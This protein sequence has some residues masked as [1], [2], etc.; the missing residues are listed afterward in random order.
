MP[1]QVHQPQSQVLPVAPVAPGMTI[2]TPPVIGGP[3][4]PPVIGGPAP[5]IP[6]APVAPIAPFAGTPQ[7][8]SNVAQN[9]VSIEDQ[10]V[11][12][13]YIAAQSNYLKTEVINEKD[14]K[15]IYS[16]FY[17]AQSELAPNAEGKIETTRKVINPDGTENVEKEENFAEKYSVVRFRT[18][19]NKEWGEM[20]A[21]NYCQVVMAE[22]KAA[23]LVV[24]AVMPEGLNSEARTSLTNNL[25]S[26]SVYRGGKSNLF[27]VSE[28]QAIQFIGTSNIRALQIHN[29]E[30]SVGQEEGPDGY[31]VI[32]SRTVVR[33]TKAG[34]VVYK[35][36]Y[37]RRSKAADDYDQAYTAS[38]PKEV[39]QKYAV[40]QDLSD[41][42]GTTCTDDSK[43]TNLAAFQKVFGMDIS[44]SK[45]YGVQV[46]YNKT[47]PD[48]AGA[49]NPAEAAKEAK[50]KT[51]INPGDKG[52]DKFESLGLDEKAVEMFRKF[53]ASTTSG[54]K[55]VNISEILEKSFR[56]GQNF[57]MGKGDN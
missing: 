40:N 11:V 17:K 47:N 21:K 2:A 37:I 33:G 48:F 38:Y 25:Y 26:H 20:R 9:Q 29:N 12:I 18:F 45:E 19:C 43:I 34:K 15:Q 30:A 57:V 6:G 14:A 35:L 4:T 32:D 46:K 31:V 1:Q 36:K 54:P 22:A 49:S 53:N 27:I 52:W 44:P 39:I 28:K 24:K 51:Y 23:Y 7:V 13:G 41:K 5:T 56:S 8:A 16:T 55:P 42:R 50:E 3:A 10:I